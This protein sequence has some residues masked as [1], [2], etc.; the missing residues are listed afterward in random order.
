[1]VS[2]HVSR[3]ESSGAGGEGETGDEERDDE[4]I[5]KSVL[6][7]EPAESLVSSHPED[8]GPVGEHIESPA[9]PAD[10]SHQNE[11]DDLLGIVGELHGEAGGEVRHDGFLVVKP[12]AEHGEGC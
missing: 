8:V 10:H 9:Q 4:G 5:N 12:D 11:D 7:E 6:L 1:M 2:V 3:L